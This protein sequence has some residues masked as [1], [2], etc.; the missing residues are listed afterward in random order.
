MIKKIKCELNLILQ[1]FDNIFTTLSYKFWT[2]KFFT[3]YYYILI[4]TQVTV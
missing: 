2:Q 4:V 1:H 3:G